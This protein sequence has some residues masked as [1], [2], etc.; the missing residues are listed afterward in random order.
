MIFYNSG[1]RGY[2]SVKAR[3]DQLKLRTPRR[4]GSLLRP[5]QDHVVP[6]T[7]CDWPARVCRSL[8]CRPASLVLPE[9]WVLAAAYLPGNIQESTTVRSGTESNGREVSYH[10]IADACRDQRA[11]ACRCA[12]TLS[13]KLDRTAVKGAS[14]QPSPRTAV[15]IWS[16]GK[17]P[18]QS[19]VLF[20]K[21]TS[22]QPGPYQQDLDWNAILCNK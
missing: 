5:A 19:R 4:E 21:I 8:S 3:L 9:R 6:A 18:E 17:R 14:S 11:C 15:N 22:P 12:T 16:A 10:Y 2:L 7:S 1:F 20:S 13:S